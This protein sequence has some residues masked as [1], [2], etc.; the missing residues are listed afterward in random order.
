MYCKILL[1][2]MLTTE[3]LRRKRSNWK[4]DYSSNN[5][6]FSFSAKI[7]CKKLFVILVKN[8]SLKK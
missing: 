3:S 7:Y 4:M 6:A 5:G 2:F 8:L 1:N